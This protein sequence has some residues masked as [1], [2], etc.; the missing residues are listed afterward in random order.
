MIDR[1]IL[2]FALLGFRV[3]NGEVSPVAANE[4]P[5]DQVCGRQPVP[6]S[7]KRG[8]GSVRFLWIRGRSGTSVSSRARAGPTSVDLDSLWS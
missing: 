1:T 5:V 2:L 8:R 3:L 7:A 6:P 4:C